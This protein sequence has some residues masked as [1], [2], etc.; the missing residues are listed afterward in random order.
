M[1]WKDALANL[2]ESGTIPQ[3]DD[4]PQEGVSPVNEAPSNK[5]KDKIHVVIEK[6]GRKGKTA[7]IAEGFTCSDEELLELASR[8]KQKL[9]CGGSA[10]GGEIL[11]QGECRE[12][13]VEFLRGEGYNAK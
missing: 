11:I 10:R 9:G 5:K 3:V 8:A 13:L 12:R 6:K 1:D 2:Q 7:T 4:T